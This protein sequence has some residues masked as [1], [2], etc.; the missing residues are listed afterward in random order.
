[1]K[2]IYTK[3]GQQAKEAFIRKQVEGLERRIR[4]N[5]YVI[6]DVEDTEIEITAEDVRRAAVARQM[7]QQISRKA[8]EKS[9]ITVLL[10][11]YMVAGIISVIVGIFFDYFRSLAETPPRLALIVAGLMLTIASSFL[12]QR[13]NRRE[14]EKIRLDRKLQQVTDKPVYRGKFQPGQRIR[15]RHGSSNDRGTGMVVYLDESIDPKDSGNRY[16][17]YW[18][19]GG[20]ETNIPEEDL[21]TDENRWSPLEKRKQR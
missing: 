19:E 21:E 1:M 15:S 13:S 5:K 12:L 4:R 14:T 2:I 8:R 3:S 6:G 16:V 9:P 7:E 20:P 18:D 17:V 11:I 10:Q